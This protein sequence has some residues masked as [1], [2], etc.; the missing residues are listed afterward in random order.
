MVHKIAKN[1]YYFFAKYLHLIQ[2]E[3]YWRNRR[4][5]DDWES[6]SRNWLIGYF[7]SRTHPH[8][9]LILKEVKK[10]KP[11]NI[12]EVGCSVAPNLMRISDEFPGIR[13]A[14]VD[15]NEESIQHAST[16]LPHGKFSVASADNLP[17]KDN[18]FDMVLVDAVLLYVPPKKIDKTLKEL[19]RVTKKNLVL[20]EWFAEKEKVVFGH[21]A[22][23]YPELFYPYRVDCVKITRKDW[24]ADN[25]SQIGY[26]FIVHK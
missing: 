12:L 8:R 11:S 21:Q 10:L 24:P 3:S 26:M 22:R 7:E 16:Y 13:L 18:S 1:I 20:I 25:W 4:G 14:G 5:G 2:G 6:S 15:V 17:F 19:L 9:E 23:N